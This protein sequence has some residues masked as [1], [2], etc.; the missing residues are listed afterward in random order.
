M[1]DL[2]SVPSKFGAVWPFGRASAFADAEVIHDGRFVAFAFDGGDSAAVSASD[3]RGL[4]GVAGYRGA[5]G[6]VL[7]GVRG[8]ACGAA[9]GGHGVHGADVRKLREAAA[10]GDAGTRC[11]VGGV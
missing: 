5:A 7:P 8:A 9:A 4:R 6:G 1:A 3:W 10:G 11:G 2:L